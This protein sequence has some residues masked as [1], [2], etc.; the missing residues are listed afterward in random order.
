MG[1]N[2]NL[3]IVSFITLVLICGLN[4]SNAQALNGSYTVGGTSPDFTTLQDAKHALITNGMSGPVNINI[5]PGI[6]SRENPPGPVLVL[7][8]S[9]AGLSE[10]N[11]LTFQPDGASG[12]NAD[13][14]ILK[15]DCDNTTGP[16]D[17]EV[18]YSFRDFVTF[19]NLRPYGRHKD[20]LP[21]KPDYIFMRLF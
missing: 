14:V 6:Y 7:D 15:I 4:R 8:S 18:V 11:R 5:C 12:G 20:K 13:N 17:K 10:T 21:V 19:K 9:I 1:I 2:K 3:M 16:S